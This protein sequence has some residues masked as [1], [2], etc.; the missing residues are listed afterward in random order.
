[1]PEW[2]GNGFNHGSILDADLNRFDLAVE[3]QVEQALVHVPIHILYEAELFALGSVAACSGGC[4]H[5]FAA[6]PDVQVI[7]F[8]GNAV[9][10]H[11]VLD[12][13]VFGLDAYEAAVG[14][15]GYGNAGGLAHLQVLAL[16]ES[17]KAHG[18]KP[19]IGVG[20]VGIKLAGQRE[21]AGFG[22]NTFGGIS[23][24]AKCRHEGTCNQDSTDGKEFL[25]K[26]SVFTKITKKSRKLRACG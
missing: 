12:C 15:E 24:H 23:T 13:A 6:I 9:G 17:L 25:H 20:R 1:M 21:G 16:G 3:R 22:V 11:G 14:A 26:N 18:V 5:P 4:E 2:V 10:V 7:S 8:G 19:V